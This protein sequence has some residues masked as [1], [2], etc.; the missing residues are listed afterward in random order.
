MTKITSKKNPALALRWCGVLDSSPVFLVRR[1]LPHT[2]GAN[3]YEDEKK[4][5]AAHT[6][7]KGFEALRR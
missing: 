3:K 4:E 1:D 6:I 2:S 7:H 5:C